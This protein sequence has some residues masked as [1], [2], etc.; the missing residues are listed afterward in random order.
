MDDA[1]LNAGQSP[2]E[3]ETKPMLRTEPD[4][5]DQKHYVLDAGVLE[6]YPDIIPGDDGCE[7][8]KPLV[9]LSRAHL[10]ITTDAIKHLNTSHTSNSLTA[11]RRLRNI[12][13]EP[14]NDHPASGYVATIKVGE[15][16][17]SV[18]KCDDD[19]TEL[20]SIAKEHHWQGPFTLLTNNDARALQAYSQGLFTSGYHY[21][22]PEPYTGRRE[23]TVP[24][25]IFNELWNRHFIARS[26]FEIRMPNEAPL[27]PNE[28]II[29]HPAEPDV[30]NYIEELQHDKYFRNI[31][32]YDLESDTL[33][34]L[35]YVQNFPLP[36]KNPGQAIYVEA[37]SDPNIAAVICTGPAG[38]GK[39]FVSTVFG[40]EACKSGQ[41]LGVTVVPCEN[42]SNIGALPGDLDDK[43]DPDVQPMKN[44]L[45][46]YLLNSRDYQRELSTVRKHGAKDDYDEPI[47]DDGACSGKKKCQ[48]KGNS[49]DKNNKDSTKENGKSKK[50]KKTPLRARLEDHVEVIWENW[51]NSVPIEVARG[52]DFSY[53][54]AIYDEAQDQSSTQM[55]TLIKRLGTDGKIVIT[56]DINQ[57]HNPKL[58]RDDNGLVYA[59]WLLGGSALVAQVTFTPDEVIRHPLVREVAQRQAQR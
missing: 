40:Y 25:C 54:I 36:L 2:S 24:N 12:I 20:L 33:M 16:T 10:I 48:K 52:R 9:D 11:L 34:S 18:V 15:A 55:D 8:I 51:F 57:I 14:I 50:G 45:R 17:I 49:Q 56:G 59:S 46:N 58:T 53:E 4:L 41:Y 29:M 28:F 30:L 42:R 47:S 19:F 5:N 26:E 27:M 31:A 3:L 32:R 13:D 22:L 21:R 38:S 39:T 6:L 35:K 43:M 1:K 37:L 7:P 23:I 44:A